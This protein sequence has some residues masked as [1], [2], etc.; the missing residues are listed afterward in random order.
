MART[1][2]SRVAGLR[3]EVLKPECHPPMH[4]VDRESAE[5]LNP[6]IQEAL[7]IMVVANSSVNPLVYGIFNTKKNHHTQPSVSRTGMNE[8]KRRT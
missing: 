1:N 5:N 4:I 7:F 8:S 3:S 6:Y 2:I